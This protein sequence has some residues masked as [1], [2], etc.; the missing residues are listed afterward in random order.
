MNYARAKFQKYQKKKKRNDDVNDC[1][2]FGPTK[3]PLPTW[4]NPLKPYESRET[5]CVLRVLVHENPV[6]PG[7]SN[8][9]NN[10]ISSTK[11]DNGVT[12]FSLKKNPVKPG[13]NPREPGEQQQQQQRMKGRPKNV[14]VDTAEG[15]RRYD[16]HWIRRR[17]WVFFCVFFL[18]SSAE[19]RGAAFGAGG[20]RL[21]THARR[22]TPTAAANEAPCGPPITTTTS[23]TTTAFIIHHLKKSLSFSST[24][25]P[26]LVCWFGSTLV[27][28]SSLRTNAKK[29]TRNKIFVRAVGFRP[30]PPSIFFF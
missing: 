28:L 11:S 20:P 3:N 8:N 21:S 1:Q 5:R 15:R 19:R 12:S 26:L 16:Y 27:Q 25:P 17:F 13:K 7:K 14:R 9:N 24:P 22:R 4:S 30:R 23:T 10:V 2:P 29:K 18:L 6:K